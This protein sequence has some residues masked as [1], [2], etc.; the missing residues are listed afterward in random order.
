M[1][2]IL[3]AISTSGNSINVINAVIA[4]KEKGIISIALTGNGGGN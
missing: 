2:E 1:R 4:A 3:L